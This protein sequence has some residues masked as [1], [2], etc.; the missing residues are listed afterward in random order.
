M[1]H[2]SAVLADVLST[3]IMILGKARGMD[4]IRSI[5]NT[6]VVL[7][8]DEGQMSMTPGLESILIMIHEP[9]DEP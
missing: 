7:V 2:D 6:E 1:I 4:L 3:A 9:L 5:E 8:D